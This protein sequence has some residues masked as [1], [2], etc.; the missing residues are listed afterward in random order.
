MTEARTPERGDPRFLEA[1]PRDLHDPP[2][3]WHR[4]AFIVK[5]L[6]ATIARTVPELGVRPGGRVLDYG[7]ADLPYRHLFPA[8]A[9]YLA[10]DLAG[11]PRANVE[12]A[13]DG[14]V[15]VEDASCDA[16]ISTQV[17]EHVTD[18]AVYLAECARVLRPG[19]RLLLST[20]GLMVWHPD[21]VDLWRWTCEGLKAAV[22]DAGLDV[23]RFEGVMGLAATG[24]QLVQDAFYWRL[25]APLR[26]ALA[27][28]LQTLARVADRLE[29]QESRD[30]NA[31]VFLVVARRP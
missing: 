8:D 10:A 9:D 27:L 21:P 14:T 29:P 2:P 18:P 15:P 24:F 20:H 12:V 7:C 5:E 6:P 25:P 11:N 26:P 30:R 31:M 19:G 16:V 13:A 1:R 3:P 28:L 22:A 17:L 4:L 23:V